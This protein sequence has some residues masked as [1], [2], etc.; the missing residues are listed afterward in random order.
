MQAAQDGL[1]QVLAWIGALTGTV[2]LL[3]DIYKWRKSGPKIEMTVSPNMVV[4]TPGVGVNHTPHIGI[5]VT[6]TGTARTTLKTIGVTC[7]ASWWKQWR[8]KASK[9]FVV[10]DTG[11]Y[12]RP[13]PHILEIGEEWRPFLPQESLLDKIDKESRIFFQLWHSASKKPVSTQ[14]IV[15]RN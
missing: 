3:W 12:C 7:Y 5:N 9:N 13:L 11:P 14:L 10:I 15:S 8:K 2:A 4:A 6:N 1:T